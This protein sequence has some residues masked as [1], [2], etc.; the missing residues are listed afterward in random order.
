[1][2]KY[3]AFLMIFAL[4]LACG[5]NKKPGDTPVQ[6]EPSVQEQPQTPEQPTPEPQ[7]QAPQ[8]PET[9]ETPAVPEVPQAPETPEQPEVPQRPET[10]AE[11]EVQ[12][13]AGAVTQIS[14]PEAIPGAGGVDCILPLEG[15]IV[16]LRS[17]DSD[18]KPE[19]VIYDLEKHLLIENGLANLPYE[20]IVESY[21]D[22]DTMSKTLSDKFNQYKAL[23][24][25]SCPETPS[26]AVSGQGGRREMYLDEVPDYLALDFA[27]E[28]EQLKL[29]AGR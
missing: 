11:P 13:P 27:V 26:G 15:S 28:Y 20:G 23:L 8:M 19:L 22:V 6:D 29:E 10:P 3:T 1:M 24:Q 2:K 18:G 7:P 4:L 21:F 16:A 9:P 14:L 17:F 12:E 5:C 25:K